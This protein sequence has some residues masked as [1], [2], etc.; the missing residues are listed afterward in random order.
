MAEILFE[1]SGIA[2]ETTAGTAV[3]APTHFLPN[4]INLQPRHTIS[5]RTASGLRA[6]HSASKITKEWT[7]W[8]MPADGLDTL[9]LPVFLESAVAGGVAATQPDAL[10][11]PTVYLR[12][13]TRSQTSTTERTLTIWGGD[14]NVQVFRAAYG[15][16]QGFTISG[17]ATGDDAVTL[18]ASGMAQTMATVAN[19]TFP[20]MLQGPMITPLESQVWLD[21]TSA[22]GTTAITGRMISAVFSVDALR[23]DPKYLFV[24]PGGQKTYSRVGANATAATLALRFE[25]LD[26][27]QWNVL[28][29]GT[30][31]KAR[32]RFNGPLINATYYHFVEV[33]IYGPMSDPGWGEFAGT[34]RTLDV[35]I[36]SQYD[37]T[38]GHDWAVR[39]QNNRATL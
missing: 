4:R 20:A 11:H 2:L 26:I 28:M 31:V 12:T 14:P 30:S 3:A 24:G 8:T 22:I 39:V 35:T 15:I 17:D 10:N 16:P 38:A 33:D 9:N 5:R 6:L 27:A 13:Y 34:N 19:P 32:V 21:T 1:R 25:L 7:E 37:A 36:T 29:A 18:E 23:G